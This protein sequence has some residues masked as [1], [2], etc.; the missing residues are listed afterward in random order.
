MVRHAK[1]HNPFHILLRANRTIVLAVLWTALAACVAGSLVFDVADW[2]DAWRDLS[3]VM[4]TMA[5]AV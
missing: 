5:A 1:Y 2:L 4:L 3:I